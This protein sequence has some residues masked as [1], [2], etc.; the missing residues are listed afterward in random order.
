MSGDGLSRILV[1]DD[2]EMIRRGLRSLIESHEGW[3]V[4]GEATD[5]KMA[6]ELALALTPDVVVM[7]LSMPHLNGF[8]AARRILTKLRQVRIL[9]LSM[10]DSEQHA[11]EAL[12]SGAR[13]YILKSDAGEHLLKALTALLGGDT[14]FSSPIAMRLL[15][16][17]LSKTLR[18][19]SSNRQAGPLTPREREILQLLTE[20][21]TNKEVGE[22]L[23][24]SVKTAETHR[25]RIMRK[26]KIDSVAELVRYAIRN[27][28]ISP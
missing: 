28:I 26:L 5:G 20:G 22:F 23:Q 11:R 16:R 17:D 18:K 21:K 2:H 3:S 7:D 15:T 24:I 9:I 27:G 10:H 25:A 6:V 14:Y 12:A 13:G 4:C 8:D 19:T 1:V